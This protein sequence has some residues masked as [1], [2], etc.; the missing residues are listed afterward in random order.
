MAGIRSI[1]FLSLFAFMS[2]CLPSPIH[3]HS[4]VAAK[5]HKIKTGHKM[6]VT[7]KSGEILRGRMGASSNERFTLEPMNAKG[8]RRAIAYNQVQNI[9][10]T[11]LSKR[12]KWIIFAVI[13]V[14]VGIVAG[15]TI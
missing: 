1:R 12:D 15:A 3:A 13:W 6:E 2:L 9:R 14:G 8:A 5:V 4:D 7:L 10:A 11:G